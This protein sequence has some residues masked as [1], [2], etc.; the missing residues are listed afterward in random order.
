MT[1]HGKDRVV[2]FK[3]DRTLW[4]TIE[5]L[6]NRS[7]FIRSAILSALESSCPLCKGTGIL[8]PRQKDHW[9]EFARDHFLE[10]CAECH[11]FRLVCGKE[12]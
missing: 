4:E 9:L 11:E 2:T 3:V 12:A 6:P 1:R 5:G 10:E 7:E 8:T